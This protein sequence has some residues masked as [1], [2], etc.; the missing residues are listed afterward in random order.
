[1]FIC[2]PS[3]EVDPKKAAA[4]EYSLA[5]PPAFWYKILQETYK[6]KISEWLNEPETRKLVRQSW[7]TWNMNVRLTSPQGENTLKLFKKVRPT[8]SRLTLLLATMTEI[9]I[10]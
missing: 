8:I 7:M 1:M 2:W 3:S 4:Q 10:C 6:R 5:D 9:V